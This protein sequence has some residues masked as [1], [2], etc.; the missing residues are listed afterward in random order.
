MKYS[1]IIPVYNRPDEV[2]ELLESLTRQS[3]ADFEVI[4]VE[5][6]SAVTCEEVVGRYVQ[7]LDVKYLLQPNSGPGQARN[8]GAG[9]ARGEWL[10]ILDSDCVAPP[11]YLETVERELAENPCEAF[12]GPDRAHEDFTP[13]QK[14]INYSM[15]SFLTTGGIRGG[16]RKLD[17]FYPRSFNMGVL[18]ALYMSLGG[19]SNMRFGEDIDFSI[20]VLESGARVSLLPGAWVWHKRRTDFMK[21]FRQVHNSG[22]ARIN[23]YKRH[24]GSLKRVH[25]LPAVFTVGVVSLLLV[26]LCGAPFCRRAWCALLP[27]ALYALMVLA[28]STLLCGSLRVGCLSVCASFVQLMGYGF[29]FIEAWWKRCV[30]GREEELQSFR[31]TFYK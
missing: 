31:G 17:R 28:H 29:G 12:G 23:L 25:M 19:F 14:A 15:T 5:D 10:L 6:G 24:P 11:A 20:R 16:K 18:R 21:F 9:H 1:F 3:L 22:M 2:D 27:I 4:V 7:R 30:L 13:V 8:T 26:A